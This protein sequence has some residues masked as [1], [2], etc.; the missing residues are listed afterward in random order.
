MELELPKTARPVLRSPVMVEREREREPAADDS[1]VREGSPL[2][3]ETSH[4]TDVFWVPLERR[5]QRHSIAN[6]GGMNARTLERERNISNN[7]NTMK[8]MSDQISSQ[9]SSQMNRMREFTNRELSASRDSVGTVSRTNGN[10]IG[11]KLGSHERHKEKENVIS[12]SSTSLQ[13]ISANT[14]ATK[15]RRRQDENDQCK[16][17]RSTVRAIFCCLELLKV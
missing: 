7:N 6:P 13:T 8:R 11:T 3:T 2:T 5:L 10:K 9:L 1:H 16:R 17:V 4:T 12:R 15:S 14:L